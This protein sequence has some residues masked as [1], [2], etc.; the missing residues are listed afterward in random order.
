MRK[1]VAI[2]LAMAGLL[3]GVFALRVGDLGVADSWLVKRHAGQRF[4]SLTW[5][6][7]NPTL[8]GKM[9]SDL[10]A[11]HRFVGAQAVAVHQLLGPSQCYVSYD[12]EPCYELEYESAKYRLEFSVNH[13]DRPGQVLS[14][15]VKH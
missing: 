14:V 13:S 6:S 8:R 4:D 3:L 12:D 11:K 5:L 9:V 15:D 2:G 1:A 10:A 7:A